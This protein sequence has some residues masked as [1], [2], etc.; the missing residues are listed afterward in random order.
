MMSGLLWLLCVFDGQESES[1]SFAGLTEIRTSLLS[2][3]GFS[4]GDNRS[5][6][7]ATG[8]KKIVFVILS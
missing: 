5:S 3:G 2:F 6:A 4:L 7:A 1:E 8:K